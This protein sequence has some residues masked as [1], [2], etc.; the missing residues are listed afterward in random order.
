L[1]RERLKAAHDDREALRLLARSSIRLGRDSSAMS[2]YEQ[3]GSSAMAAEDLYLLGIALARTGHPKG[4]IE[5]WEQALKADPDHA[6][7]LHEMIKVQ[8]QAN[9]FNAAAAAASRLARHPDW[10]NRAD[11][12]MGWIELNR[13]H[14]GKA[15][16]LWQQ[17]LAREPPLTGNTSSSLFGRKDLAR[18]LL[19]ARRPAEARSQL[20]TILAREPNAEASWLM[21]RAYLQEGALAEALAAFKQAGAFAEENPTLPDPAPFA[22]AASCAPCHSEKYQAQQ[23]S[24]HARTFRRISE[25]PDLELPQASF[26]DPANSQ[27]T[28]HFRRVGDHLQQETHTEG[29]IYQ[30]VLDY[31]FGSGDRGKT[32]VGHDSE[33]RNFELRLSVYH[34]K[35]AQSLWDITS[36]RAL[37]PASDQGFLGIPLTNDAVRRCFSCHVTS[38]DVFLEAPAPASTDCG[39]GCEKCHGPGANHLL[40]VAARFPD[41][42]IARPSL[43]SGARVVKV[44][45][46]CHGLRGQAVAPDEP[47]AV[48]FQGTT[49]TWSRCYTESQDR[50]DCVT[51]HDPHSNVSTTTTRYEAKCLVCHASSQTEEASDHKEQLRRFDLTEAPRA[52]TCSVNPTTGCISC[53][54]PTVEGII[55]HSQFTDHFIRV[56][57]KLSTVIGQ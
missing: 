25:L 16:Q 4:S 2:V 49:L 9:L 10:R 47:T 22:G 39:I 12:L 21:S 3:L 18:A 11:A 35:T 24:R 20:E 42:A 52:T 41:L 54:M 1:A 55:P 15:A 17:V 30:A 27:V 31:A 7:T 34:E 53:H 45:A 40:A 23:S 29:H 57:R 56:H 19:R 13:D 26:S 36:G 44:C 8:L 48:R 50:L 32:M 28:H 38:P 14:P 46:Q 5:V 6:E 37:H 51:C 33:G 43:A